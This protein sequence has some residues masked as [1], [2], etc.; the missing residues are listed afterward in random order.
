MIRSPAV[1]SIYL[2]DQ[3]RILISYGY[4]MLLLGPKAG[5]ELFAALDGA[6][7]VL[8]EGGWN[9]L[10]ER[11]VPQKTPVQVTLVAE[12]DIALPENQQGTVLEAFA[13]LSRKKED[14]EERARQAEARVKELE[15]TLRS[16]VEKGPEA[17][18]SKC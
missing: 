9:G 15:C 13:N 17:E 4:N 7:Y 10:P 11:Y 16:I 5:Q 14:A 1:K 8:K 3:M 6:K 18:V 12:D 2:E